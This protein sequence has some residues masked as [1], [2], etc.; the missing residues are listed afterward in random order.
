MSAMARVPHTAGNKTR[1]QVDYS[2]WLD[3]GATLSTAVNACSVALDASTPVTD[4]TLSGLQVTSTHL[5][6]FVQ[7][8]SV[9]EV[10]TVDVMITDSRGEIANDTVDF[11]VIAP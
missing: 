2:N 5:Y 3:E 8:G 10:F 11:F 4:V 6:F 7:G 9:S 1:Y